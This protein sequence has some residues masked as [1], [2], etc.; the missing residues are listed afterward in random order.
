MS[1]IESR[2]KR[3]S[4]RE[5]KKE[6]FPRKNDKDKEKRKPKHENFLRKVEKSTR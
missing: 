4:G 6:K 1:D 5:K 3:Y 2:R